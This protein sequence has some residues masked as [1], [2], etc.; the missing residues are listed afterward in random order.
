[1]QVSFR[2][3]AGDVKFVVN[4]T[5]SKNLY[6]VSVDGN[7]FTAPIDKTNLWLNKAL[8][9]FDRRHALKYNVIWTLPVGRGNGSVQICQ[10]GRTRSSAAGIWVS[11]A[12]GKAAARS[13]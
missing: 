10:G 13:R 4:Y 12:S 11:S 5:W 7:G 1:M 8:D 6:N 9:D 2:R 3:T